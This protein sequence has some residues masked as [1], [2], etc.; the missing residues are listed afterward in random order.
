MVNLLLTYAQHDPAWPIT[1]ISDKLKKEQGLNVAPDPTIT[2]RT[3]A[4]QLARCFGRTNFTLKSGA[5]R[6]VY[7]V[8]NV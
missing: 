1:L 6:E 3:L 5:Y 7:D 4:V 2:V 8:T